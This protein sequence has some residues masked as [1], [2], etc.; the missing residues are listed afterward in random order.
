MKMSVA[1]S[2]LDDVLVGLSNFCLTDGAFTSL[3]CC[4]PMSDNWSV[5]HA[6][7]TQPKQLGFY[8]KPMSFE[9]HCV[10]LQH[11]L[12]MYLSTERFHSERLNEEHKDETRNI[13]R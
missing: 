10:L 5:F 4:P 11:V 9:E 6:L 12:I 1:V 2:S 8:T 13:E 3:V 7:Q